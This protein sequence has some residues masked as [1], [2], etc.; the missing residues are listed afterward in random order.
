LKKNALD[1]AVRA[2]GKKVVSDLKTYLN[3]EKVTL[4]FLESGSN[5][6]TTT[7]FLKKFLYSIE[8]YKFSDGSYFIS[9]IT[10]KVTNTIS[11]SDFKQKSKLFKH[12]MRTD[13]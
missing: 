9:P 2:L 12:G 10:F 3:I 1:D 6:L 7:P 8:N 4:S 11:K 13:A 5:L